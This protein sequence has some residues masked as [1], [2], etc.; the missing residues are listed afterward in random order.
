M[1]YFFGLRASELAGIKKD[2]HHEHSCLD[3]ENGF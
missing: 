1:M 2:F 3:L